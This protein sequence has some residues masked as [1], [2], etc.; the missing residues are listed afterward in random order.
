MNRTLL[1]VSEVAQYFGIPEKTV[2]DQAHRRVGVGQFA[3]RVG[4][5]L[6]WEPSDIDAFVRA[7]KN[8]RAGRNG[9]TR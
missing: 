8:T 2:R 7:Q 5:Y 4:R 3:F 9:G 1:G 6:R